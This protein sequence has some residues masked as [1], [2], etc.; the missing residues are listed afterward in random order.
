MSLCNE[1][2]IEIIEHCN[3]KQL[4][5]LKKVNSFFRYYS[6]KIFI[7]KFVQKY[8][9]NIRCNLLFKRVKPLHLIINPN[10]NFNN[11]NLIKNITEISVP[12]MLINYDVFQRG[13]PYYKSTINPSGD[14]IQSFTVQGKNRIIYWWEDSLEIMVFKC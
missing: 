4:L 8:F 10:Y 12:S 1:L 3:I 11:W 5:V 6:K 2:Y 9:K 13:L 14:I 7:K